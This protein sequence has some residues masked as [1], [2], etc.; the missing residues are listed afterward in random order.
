M[1]RETQQA[2]ALYDLVRISAALHL[3][4]NPGEP[5]EKVLER[6]PAYK[7]ID[8]CSGKPYKWHPQ[9]RMLY[10]IGT[11]RMDN[12]GVMDWKT[13]TSDF[14]LPVRLKGRR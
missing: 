11:D 12:G 8:P 7:T 5:V 4:D 6:L 9:K 2:L 1:I 13:A 10:S 14:A 3:E